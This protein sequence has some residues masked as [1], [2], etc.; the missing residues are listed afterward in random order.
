MIIK[1]KLAVIAC[2]LFCVQNVISQ[3]KTIT[4]L[5]TDTFGM[6]VPGATIIVQGTTNGTTSDFDGNFSL[7]NVS[8]TNQIMFSYIGYTTQIITVGNQTEINIILQES[9]ES[10]DEVVVVG[11]GTQ[12]KALVTGASVNVKGEAI[13]KLNTSTAME[14]LQGVTPGISITRNNGQPGAGTKVTIRG[15]G[16]V[17]NSNPLYI[18]DGVAAG[19]IDYLNPS[20]IESIDVLK[21]AASA[22]IY[23]ARA[24]N[25]VVVYTTKQ[26]SRKKQKMKVL[27][28]K[29]RHP[30]LLPVYIHCYGL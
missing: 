27:P 9:L 15:L 29:P 3:E 26:G 2:L 13:A 14:A 4:G 1:F 8:P 17:G 25:G 18:I 12:K 10:L 21:D 11:Y 19:N 7:S 24:A 23:G 16:T 30:T 22:S 5:V 6:P 28:I 20:D